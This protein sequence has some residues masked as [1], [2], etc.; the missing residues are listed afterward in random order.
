MQLYDMFSET[1]VLQSVSWSGALTNRL[2][3][4]R[5]Q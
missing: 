3:T 5:N 1:Q 2:G 4:H